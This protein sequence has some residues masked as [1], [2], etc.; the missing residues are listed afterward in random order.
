[1]KRGRNPDRGKKLLTSRSPSASPDAE[2]TNR[3]S[4]VTVCSL[5]HSRWLTV[6]HDDTSA[7]QAIDPP[8]VVVDGH[9]DRSGAITRKCL[10][11]R[12]ADLERHPRNGRS[13]FGL[14]ESLVK[15]GKDAGAGWVKREFEEAWKNADVKLSLDDL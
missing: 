11:V 1:M 3:R 2:P 4:Q 9:R 8:R 10:E 7:N 15:Q 12:R 13:L 14:H 5:T 6:S